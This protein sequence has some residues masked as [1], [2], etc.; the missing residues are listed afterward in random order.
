MAT[1]TI[2]SS[3]TRPA[4]DRR[5][6]HDDL[7]AAAGLAAGAALGA[8]GWVLGITVWLIH[9]WIASH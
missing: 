4:T 5:G 1:N 6:P 7:T 3:T 8:V 2:A 9:H